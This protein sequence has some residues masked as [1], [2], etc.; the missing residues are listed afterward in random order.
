MHTPIQHTHTQQHHE[1]RSKA[2]VKSLS[3]L[4]IEGVAWITG[5]FSEDA[6]PRP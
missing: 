2:D 1:E 3:G 5:T 4:L 6:Q